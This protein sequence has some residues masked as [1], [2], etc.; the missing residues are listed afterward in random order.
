MININ[1]KEW[2]TLEAADIE[3]MLSEK[4]FEENFYFELKKDNV[5]NKTF[6][7]EVSAFANTFGGYILI[8][9][10]DEKNIEGCKE[11]NEQRIHTTIHDSITPVPC[12]DVK[13]FYCNNNIVYVVKIDEGSEPP[14]ITNTGKIFER[15]SSGSFP[16]ND[17]IRLSQIYN[18]REQLLS[19]FEQKISIQPVERNIGNVSGYIDTGFILVLSDSQK[20]ID[21]FYDVNLEKVA[22]K[23]LDNKSS[24]NLTRIGNSI[25]Y[26]PGCLSSSKDHLPAH[27]NNFLEIMS[28]GS[29]RM[30]ILLVSDD[31]NDS[32]VNMVYIRLFLDLY[33]DVYSQ[34]MKSLFPN[35][36]VYA[37]K[38]ESLT[39][40]K[41][42][43]PVYF[44]DESILKSHPDL[45]SENED[46]LVSVKRYHL[47][48]GKD[49]VITN[50]R[51]PKI[52]LYTID[53]H[54]I[55]RWHTEYSANTIIDELF[56]SRFASLGV[57]AII[58]ENIDD[59]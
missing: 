20:P 43:Y 12:F 30:R 44:Y 36:F 26:T 27:T 2:N 57:N 23:F 48:F 32:N 15:L 40:L 31:Q 9:I 28:D 3:N 45:K 18:R 35:N 10:T 25:V 1:G 19:K 16:I 56:F 17:S 6:I 4:D 53:K 42:F 14:Y 50:D 41:Q 54:Q 52:G 5:S 49:I 11:W 39:V 34:I 22:K 38:Y 7:K 58:E 29:A 21:L 24:A 46:M 55:E 59:K 51:I 33:K 47:K 37:K 13:K 8:G